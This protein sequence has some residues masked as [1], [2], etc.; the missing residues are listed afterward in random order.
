MRYVS[1]KSTTHKCERAGVFMQVT[2]IKIT[3][4]KGNK[5]INRI[6]LSG[7]TGPGGVAALPALPPRR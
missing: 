4:S 3:E 5:S 7:S 6:D 2:I 1:E